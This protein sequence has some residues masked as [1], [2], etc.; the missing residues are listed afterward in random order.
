MAVDKSLNR[1]YLVLCACSS[2]EVICSPNKRRK[3]MYG[4]FP[5][6]INNVFHREGLRSLPVGRRSSKMKSKKKN[7]KGVVFVEARVSKVFIL[8][9][10]RRLLEKFFEC[11]S[12]LSYFALCAQMRPVVMTMRCSFTLTQIQCSFFSSVFVLFYV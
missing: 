6:D 7:E 8:F 9:I 1:G 5:K 2:H 10:F 11:Y 4:I 12:A 3:R